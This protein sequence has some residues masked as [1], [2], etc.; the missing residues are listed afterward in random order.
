MSF[1]DLAESGSWARLY[2]YPAEFHGVCF[3]VGDCPMG[4]APTQQEQHS[5]V[6]CHLRHCDDLLLGSL[7]WHRAVDLYGIPQDSTG[8]S[9]GNVVGYYVGNDRFVGSY[10]LFLEL[11]G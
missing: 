3:Y 7:P 10:K 6:A 8:W 5:A 4:F 9:F 11:D 2:L 1:F